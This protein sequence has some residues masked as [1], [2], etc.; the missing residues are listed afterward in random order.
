MVSCLHEN[1]D[2]HIR[3]IKV[4]SRWSGSV[5]SFNCSNEMLFQ[6]ATGDS[7]SPRNSSSCRHCWFSP[8]IVQSS[9]SKFLLFIGP[10]DELFNIY[11]WSRMSMIEPCSTIGFCNTMYM[12]RNVLLVL[13][14]RRFQ[15][16]LTLKAVKSKTVYLTSLTAFLWSTRR[17]VSWLSCQKSM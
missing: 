3:L 11:L 5:A 10:L 8:G 14:N 9:S 17:Y 13:Q 12:W 4:L 1:E 16:L 2:L 15:S 6:E 7:E